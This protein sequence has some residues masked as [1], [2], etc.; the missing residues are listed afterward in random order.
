MLSIYLIVWVIFYC[1]LGFI[2]ILWPDKTKYKISQASSATIRWWGVII[3]C[4]GIWLAI[5]VVLFNWALTLL[6][7]LGQ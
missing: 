3:F 7:S 1:I 6:K 2:I 5:A 4:A